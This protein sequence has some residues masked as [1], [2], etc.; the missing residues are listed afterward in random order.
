MKKEPEFEL[1]LDENGEVIFPKKMKMEMHLHFKDLD[2][3]NEFPYDVFPKQVRNLV[4]GYS[5]STGAHPGMIGASVMAAA[6]T[7]FTSRMWI[8]PSWHQ[9]MNLFLAMVAQPGS[10]KTGSISKGFEPVAKYQKMVKAQYK[11]DLE[12]Y[13][14]LKMDIETDPELSRDERKRQLAELV[15]PIKPPLATID[16]CTIA[17]VTNQCGRKIDRN[18]HP[19]VSIVSD[20][21][22][23]FF[24]AM[25]SQSPSGDNKA[26]IALCLSMYSGEGPSKALK[27]EDIEIDEAWMTMFG[28]IQP[29]I[30]EE[31]MA[32]DGSGLQ[33]RFNLVYCLQE[34][35]KTNIFKYME[36]GVDE[37]Y[38]NWMIDLKMNEDKEYYLYDPIGISDGKC[39]DLETA[40]YAQ[41][42]HDYVMKKYDEYKDTSCK[43]WEQSYYKFIHMLT[44]MY[45]KEAPT[46]DIVH[47]A[48]RLSA[49]FIHNY[50]AAR[51][52]KAEDDMNRHKEKV[53]DYSIK[54]LVL[55]RLISLG[56]SSNVRKENKGC[57]EKLDQHL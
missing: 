13:E 27:D 53:M 30:F 44:V 8:N 29:K 6:A 11:E 52:T 9:R 50:V 5:E 38:V 42:Y 40:V 20:E 23:G 26:F 37:E 21:M 7:M 1:N 33:D 56:I 10:N 41:S 14:R 54:V 36:P 48:Q 51:I 4:K 28:G 57:Y 24:S 25:S 47:K 43:K 16:T 18:E 45:E 39:A 15:E 55:I 31:S 49:Y 46:K 2:K 12:T 17:G 3:E 34:L 19:H 22:S 32:E 35:K